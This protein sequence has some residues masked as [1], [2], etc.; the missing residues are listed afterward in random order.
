MKKVSIFVTMLL[1][2]LTLGFSQ[3]SEWTV[4][5]AATWI[6]A[7]N[8]VRTGGNNRAHRITLNGNISV[9]MSDSSTFGNATGI[10]VTIE[11]SGSITPSSNGALLRVGSGQTIIARNLTLQGR[12]QNSA[13]LVRIS[14]GGTFRMQGRASVTGN[15]SG[16][17]VL[18]TGVFV[19]GGTFI[20]EDNSSVT[21][22]SVTN[23]GGSAY[24]GGVRIDEGGTFTMLGG[25][26]SGNTVI[27]IGN[28][29]GVIGTAMGG[30]IYIEQN[31]TFN[32]R[33][34]IITNNTASSKGELNAHS[35]GGGVCIDGG[36]FNMQGGTISANIV[37]YDSRGREGRTLTMGGG[38]PWSASG[39][40]VDISGANATFTMS[41]GTISG[42][43]SNYRSGGV[44]SEGVF[45]MSGGKISDN[46]APASGAGVDV[47]GIFTM[48]GGEISDNKGGGV[49]VYDS[50][51]M[52]GGKISGNG[53]E[54]WLGGGVCV[55]RGSFIMDNGEISGNIAAHGGGVFVHNDGTFTKNGG[56]IYGNDSAQNLRN[57]DKN[58][59]GHA[60]YEQG[61]DR[62]RNTTAGQAVGTDTYGFWMNN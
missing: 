15:S 48:S 60:I 26:I 27:A 55:N 13:S 22:N 19:N 2:I 59:K 41:G 58:G 11:G 25:T 36:T 8:G 61:N 45:N 28:E 52:K 32:M 17:A 10:T 6:D 5:N 56:I 1:G 35:F 31:C 43:T 39:G 16:E 57:I 12:N 40:G 30:G 62:W 23:N 49:D 54:S 33:A 24:G 14:S 38:L 46:T 53:S 9:P 51:I 50:F 18:T 47:F 34:G 44:C 4:N 21:N 37:S 7:V 3:T 29:S 42:N 20:M